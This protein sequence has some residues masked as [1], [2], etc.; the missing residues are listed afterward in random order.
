[1]K[2]PLSG[3]YKFN[4]GTGQVRVCPERSRRVE[5]TD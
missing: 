2:E 5:E 1:M 3:Q 4:P